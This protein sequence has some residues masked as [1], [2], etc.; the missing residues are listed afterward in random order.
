MEKSWSVLKTED[1]YKIA[2]RRTIEIF[3]SPHGTP[4]GDELDVLLPLIS[5]YEDIHY[6]LPDISD[7]TKESINA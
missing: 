7:N 5:T 3:N 2:L 1:E 6:P 4:E